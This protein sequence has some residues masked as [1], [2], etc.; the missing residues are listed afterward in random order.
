LHYKAAINSYVHRFHELAHLQLTESDWKAIEMVTGWL[1]AFREATTDMSTTSRP[2]LS[3][4]HCTFRTL[5][6]HLKDALR[7]LPNTAPSRLRNG[8]VE[9][10]AKL[11]E[12]YTKVDESYLY[13]WA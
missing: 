1:K 2:M 3:S 10:H 5:Q 9:A 4:V 13:T 8:L 6:L 12:Y 7:Q 11:A